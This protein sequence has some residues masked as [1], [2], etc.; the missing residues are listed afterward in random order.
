M[1]YLNALPRQQRWGCIR[2]MEALALGDP[3]KGTLVYQ[4]MT[5]WPAEHVQAQTWNRALLKEI[6]EA[7]GRE[8]LETGVTLWLAPAMNIHRNPL[9]GRNFEYYSEDPCLSSRMA[10]AVTE[11]VQSHPGIGIS[12]ATTGRRTDSTFPRIC[13]SGHCGKST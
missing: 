8:M 7:V 12:A 1:K 10:A 9:C 4:Y 13:Q 5:A 11:G 3:R 6:G 2:E